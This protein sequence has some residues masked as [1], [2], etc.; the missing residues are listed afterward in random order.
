MLAMSRAYIIDSSD[1]RSFKFARAIRDALAVYYFPGMWEWNRAIVLPLAIEG[2]LKSMR[3]QR[4]RYVGKQT[5]STEEDAGG[6]IK[7]KDELKFTFDIVA[8]RERE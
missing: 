7:L 5:L 2:F 1:R 6:T 8:H 3:Q 4:D